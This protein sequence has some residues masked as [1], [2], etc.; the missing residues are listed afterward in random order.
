MRTNEIIRV[1]E[2]NGGFDN[3]NHWTEKEVAQWVKANYP[4]SYYVAKNVAKYLC[5]TGGRWI[6]LGDVI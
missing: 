1:I 5:R 6:Y 3:F 4:C 2:G